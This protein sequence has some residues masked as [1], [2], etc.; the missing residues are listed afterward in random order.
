MVIFCRFSQRRRRSRFSPQSSR[1]Y[2]RGYARLPYPQPAY[3]I[4]PSDVCCEKYPHI[5]YDIP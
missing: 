4:S 3:G 2:R 1:Y 5:K